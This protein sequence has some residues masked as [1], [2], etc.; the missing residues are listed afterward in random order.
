[1]T[2][3]SATACTV[4]GYYATTSAAAE[5]ILTGAGSTWTAAEAPLPAN[6]IE[7]G[8]PGLSAVTCTS[9]TSCV[10]VGTY[11]DPSGD[12]QV[13]LE[14]GSGTTWTVTEA[15]VPANSSPEPFTQ[16]SSV[17]CATQTTCFAVGSYENTADF[18]QALLVTGS[19]PS[20]TA[21]EAPLPAN[22]GGAY[23]DTGLGSVACGSATICLATRGYV[24]VNNNDGEGMLL[25]WNGSSWTALQAPLPPDAPYGTGSLSA[26]T[27]P[28]ATTCIAA[29][30]Y[31]VQRATLNVGWLTTGAPW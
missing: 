2:C 21:A 12:D 5:L 19:G 17:T 4:V 25:S 3:T 23:P 24:D 30:Q 10:A 18:D 6:A 31:E 27:C 16:L 15:P 29:G 14:T 11:L 7:A 9:A 1:V 8:S 28:A 26:V 20:W 13:L 22:A